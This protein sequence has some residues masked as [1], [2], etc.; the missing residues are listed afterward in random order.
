MNNTLS[1]Q[2]QSIVNKLPVTL[3]FEE[4]PDR[5]QALKYIQWLYTNVPESKTVNQ[6]QLFREVISK[7]LRLVSMKTIEIEIFLIV[8]LETI[9]VNDFMIDG[10]TLVNKLISQNHDNYDLDIMYR[11]MA[12]IMSKLPKDLKERV[13][14]K[15]KL[16]IF[17]KIS[18]SINIDNKLLEKFASVNPA[19]NTPI[20]MELDAGDYNTL[21]N[22]YLREL[23][24]Y[25]E[26]K[27]YI[28]S[29][30]MEYVDIADNINKT[31]TTKP[32]TNNLTARYIDDSP[33]FMLGQNDNTLYYF[34]S[35]SGVLTE[36]PL[37]GKQ[38]PVSL[39]DLK[40][41]LTSDKVNKNDISN[42]IDNLQT[43]TTKSNPSILSSDP[44]MTTQ[45]KSFFDKIGSYFTS[46]LYKQAVGTSSNSSSLQQIQNNIMSTINTIGNT[47]NQ[48]V[49][50]LPIPPQ[51]ILN[52]VK[53]KSMGAMSGMSSGMSSGTPNSSQEGNSKSD[54]PIPILSRDI[55]TYKNN[56]TKINDDTKRII[57][58]QVI[59]DSNYQDSINYRYAN[60]NNNLE[61]RFKSREATYKPGSSNMGSSNMGS[62]NKKSFMNR[63]D[64]NDIL[65]N[66]PKY[67][68]FTNMNEE[69][70]LNKI[71]NDNKQ[72]EKVALSFVTIV[73]LI[74]LLVIFTSIR[75]KN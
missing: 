17:Q 51:Y 66:Q 31:Y 25:E 72:I 62:S 42:L 43:Q 4:S 15:Q 1:T 53:E 44:S 16:Q 61:K 28:S 27:G 38:K 52:T 33:E 63:T 58:R 23:K 41:I 32:H 6:D 37:N 50:N 8:G 36:M 24:K 30:S 46:S 19:L 49:T 74:F 45:P 57:E 12:Q 29:N 9:T 65:P 70:F 55:T 5:Q 75:N 7:E 22:K 73:I 35:S 10:K 18:E 21:N 59:A 39:T 11:I 14:G 40:T 60:N 68:S 26:S 48:S 71:K 47:N 69:H 13:T 56:Y 64:A 54:G 2:I 67:E 34:D 20:S 3:F